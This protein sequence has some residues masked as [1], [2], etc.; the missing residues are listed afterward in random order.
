MIDFNEM[1]DRHL[2]REYRPKGVGKYYPSEV[3]SCIRKVWYSY[4]FPKEVEPDLIKVFE[5]GNIMHDFV[6][7]VLKSEKTPNVE[8]VAEELPFKMDI[9]DFKVSGRVDDLIIIKR[10]NREVLVEVKSV[11]NLKYVKEPKSQHIIQLQFYMYA[12]GV[13][14]GMLLYIDKR[15][16]QSQIFEVEYDETQ[17]KA[18]VERFKRLHRALTDNQIPEPEAKLKYDM[19]WMCNYCEYKEKC[20]KE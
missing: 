5:V 15:N 19:D 7:D 17:A 1:I 6:V 13:H 20:D 18:I 4:K 16:L 9:D 3:G 2:A 12:T 8:L 14:D 10:E 11:G